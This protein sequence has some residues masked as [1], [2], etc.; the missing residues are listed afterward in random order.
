MTNSEYWAEVTECHAKYGPVD[1]C[2]CRACEGVEIA[3]SIDEAL[4]D[5]Y[6]IY[7]GF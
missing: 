2:Q 4:S 7:E 1:G 6:P 3:H 5:L